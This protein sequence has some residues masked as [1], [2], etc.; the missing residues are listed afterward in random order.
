MGAQA[1]DNRVRQSLYDPQTQTVTSP[2]H[3]IRRTEEYT[4]TLKL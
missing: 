1:D 2:K 4:N 3:A